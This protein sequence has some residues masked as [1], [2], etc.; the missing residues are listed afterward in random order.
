VGVHARKGI[1]LA[2]LASDTVTIKSCLCTI[3]LSL[4]QRNRGAQAR[5]YYLAAL[6]Q[7]EIDGDPYWIAVACTNLGG[8]ALQMGQHEE[9]LR[10]HQRVLAIH[11]ESHNVTAITQAL[12]NLGNHYRVCKQWDEAAALMRRGLVLA[13]R[14]RLADLT[15]HL[16]V[17][18]GLVELERGNGDAA[19]RCFQR[20]LPLEGHG[21]TPWLIIEAKFGL[22]R[23][24]ARR[25]DL[26]AAWDWL[27]KGARQARLIDHEH[28]LVETMIVYAEVLGAAGELER[29]HELLDA[30]TA[31][32]RADATLRDDANVI[33]IRLAPPPSISKPLPLNLERELDQLFAHSEAI[34]RVAAERV[35]T[36]P[37]RL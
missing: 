10:Y 35:G 22:A 9:S 31:D 27:A 2:R 33:R 26:A 23:V 3:G 17:N 34:S 37:E 4:E 18:L 24:A 20:T 14:H 12:N 8:L 6:K 25:G 5:R 11:E 28:Y 30:V 1:R 13:E 15:S 7:A 16:L 36:L 19:L 21:A 32:P 29:A